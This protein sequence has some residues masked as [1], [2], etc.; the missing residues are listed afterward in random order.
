MLIEEGRINLGL[1]NPTT[2]P[3]LRNDSLSLNEAR[4]DVDFGSYIPKT[5][6]MDLLLKLLIVL[7]IKK[8]IH[9]LSIG[10]KA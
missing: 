8:K 7:L 2:I 5:Y 4:L 6:Q 9:Y 10:P 1:I 3:E